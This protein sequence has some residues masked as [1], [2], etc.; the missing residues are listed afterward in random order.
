MGSHLRRTLTVVA[1]AVA[2]TAGAGV[3]ARAN[4]APGEPVGQCPPV[5]TLT[6]AS[7]G[8]ATAALDISSSGNHDGWICRKVFQHGPNAGT[9]NIIDNDIPLGVTFR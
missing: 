6:D 7:F 1:V 8:P 9:A 5:Y 2:A 3:P 4:A